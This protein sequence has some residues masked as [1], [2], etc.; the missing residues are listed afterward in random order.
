MREGVTNAGKSIDFKITEV[1]SVTNN[2]P[3]EMTSAYITCE[4]K[5]RIFEAVIDTGAGSSFIT[6]KAADCLGWGIEES[7]DLTFI[8]VNRE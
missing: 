1:N 5:C 2:E 4:I 7:T 6:K 3:E 8:T